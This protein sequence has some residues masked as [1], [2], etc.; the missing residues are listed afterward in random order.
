MGKLL[1]AE[2][3]GGLRGYGRRPKMPVGRAGD[4]MGL[5]MEQVTGTIAA[6]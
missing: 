4:A 3:L 1:V 2:D 5:L 6:K